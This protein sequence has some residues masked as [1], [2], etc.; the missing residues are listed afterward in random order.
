[1]RTGILTGSTLDR[2]GSVCAVSAPPGSLDP[3]TYRIRSTGRGLVCL[4]SLRSETAFAV[5]PCLFCILGLLRSDPA[6]R[7]PF[8]LHGMS[9]LVLQD[10][11]LQLLPGFYRVNWLS[12]APLAYLPPRSLQ[13]ELAFASSSC[14]SLTGVVRS[15]ACHLFWRTTSSL[16]VS[17][18]RVPTGGGRRK[19][20]QA[21][22]CQRSFLLAAGWW[23]TG[24][25]LGGRISRVRCLQSC[26][27][28][29]RTI[30][31]W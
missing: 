31:C 6:F 28:W 18:S 17:S 26:N 16:R 29:C 19:T 20:L 5:S 30:L 24:I 9:D 13:S 12:L 7:I 3:K 10:P 23:F 14:L 8:L 25:L 4:R 11:R 2:S 27:T 21:L 1:M 22:L 15:S